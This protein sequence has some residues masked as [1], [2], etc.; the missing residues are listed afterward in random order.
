M[1]I[2][3]NQL[4]AK[5]Q[6]ELAAVYVLSGDE[7]LQLGE[8]ADSVRSAARQAG[9]SNRVVMEAGPR[10]DWSQLTQEADSMSLFAELKIIEFR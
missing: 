9:Y 8:A 4:A 6:Q 2:P 10:F 3:L 5:L 7:P 1:R